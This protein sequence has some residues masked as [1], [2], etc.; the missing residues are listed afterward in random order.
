MVVAVLDA[1]GVSAMG[2]MAVVEAGRSDGKE[3]SFT[4]TNTL[5]PSPLEIRVSCRIQQE[6]LLPSTTS[7]S[8]CHEQA[9]IRWIGMTRAQRCI[10]LRGRA[11]GHSYSGAKSDQLRHMDNVNLF[12]AIWVL[13]LS[14]PT[15]SR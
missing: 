14:E 3:T 9:L 6:I 7:P 11:A 12:L 2:T 1:C 5:P 10:S 4:S 8:D 13:C 15:S